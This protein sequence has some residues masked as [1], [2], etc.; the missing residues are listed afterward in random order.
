VVLINEAFKKLGD[1]IYS[2]DPLL[3]MALIK[4][5]SS[6]RPLAVS[7][8]GA[9]G[10]TQIMPETARELG[11]NNIFIPDYY[12]EAVS[13]MKR[14]RDTRNSAL[15]IIN[16]I[17][18]ENGLKLS[19]QARKLMQESLELGRRRAE[20]YEKY[21]A[22]L[23]KNRNDDRLQAALSI[24]YGLK[25][26]AGLMKKYNGDISLALASYNAGEYRVRDFSGIPPYKETVGF[27]NK[28]LQFYREY[29]DEVLDK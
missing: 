25:Y 8:V 9:A 24:E 27:R 22:E 15:S 20:L 6:F 18:E 2:V 4:K 19:G 26:F 16:E 3:F 7:S 21:E 1:S 12:Q 5:E 13:L 17:T 10:L 28:I 29:L 11:M 14:E 23:V